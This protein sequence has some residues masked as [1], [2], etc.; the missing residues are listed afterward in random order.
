MV[1]DLVNDYKYGQYKTVKDIL[2]DVARDVTDEIDNE[3]I[4]LEDDIRSGKYSNEE[5]ADR[6][7]DLRKLIYG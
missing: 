1:K 2:E 5:I 4:K 7:S 3:L 6:I